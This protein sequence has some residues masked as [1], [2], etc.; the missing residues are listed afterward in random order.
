MR[1]QSAENLNYSN[2]KRANAYN[3]TSVSKRSRNGDMMTIH[4]SGYKLP[5]EAKIR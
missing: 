2:E 5:N 1:S 4:E 3:E